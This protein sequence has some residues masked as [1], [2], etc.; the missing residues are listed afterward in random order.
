MEGKMLG[1][2]VNAAAIIVA[3]TIGLL[4]RGK[5]SHRYSTIVFDGLALCTIGIGI[6]NVL[7]ANS[8]LLVIG[9]VVAGSVLGQWMGIEDRLDRM[10]HRLEEKFSKGRDGGED[11]EG[12]FAKGFI[13]STLLFCVGSM[14]I[15]GSLQSGISGDHSVLFSK[16]VLDG[17]T[18]L[19]LSSTFGPG[20][21]FSA[22]PLF[23]YQGLITIGSSFAKDLLTPQTIADM[24]AVGGVL[25]MGI[26]L[27][28]LKL[29]KISVGNMLPAVFLPVAYYA[30]VGLF[31]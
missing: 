18:S 2:I 6:M 10:S 4:L 21:L 23:I 29:K 26:G 16:S 8:M 14:A 24:S 1:T 30:I 9:S 15:V 25:I 11:S 17:V 5:V 28:I 13:T 19:L 27:N 3:S 31:L 22:V 7:E 12:D 20:V